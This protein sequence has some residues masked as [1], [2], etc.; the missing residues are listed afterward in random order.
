MSTELSSSDELLGAT[1]YEIVRE[2][3]G[4][5]AGE[6]KECFRV[7]N[8]THREALALLQNWDSRALED[9]LSHIRVVVASDSSDLFP[10]N[11][12]ANPDTTITSYRNSM[13]PLLY[14][15]TKVE[16]DEQGL[17]NLF[18]LR[19]V[20]FLD[21]A[22]DT[23]TFSV[24]GAL[25]DGALKITSADEHPARM[26]FKERV[27]EVLRG[28]KQGGTAVPVR[29][30]ASFALAAAES[31][32]G[33]PGSLE[34]TEMDCLLGRHLVSLDLFGDE[35]WRRDH[36]TSRISRRLS[37]NLLHAELASSQAADLDQDKLVEQC[38]RMNFRSAEGVDL[39]AEER[40]QWRKLCAEYCGN[41]RREI[42]EQIPYFVFEQLFSRDL[43]GLKLGDR[44]RQEIDQR[45]PDRIEEFEQL[46]VKAGLDRRDRDDAQKFL[47]KE[48]EDE[49]E[50]AL[51]DLLSKQTRR[52]VEKA[53]YPNPEKFKN[54]LLKLAQVANAMRA[55]IKSREGGGDY[56]LEM[57]LARNAD[58]A[59]PAIGLLAFLY[60]PTLQAVAEASSL[61][62]DGFEF[63]P[64]SLFCNVQPPPPLLEGRDEESDDE[65]VET[66]EWAAVPVEFA[67]FATDEDGE[68]EL[69]TALEWLPDSLERLAL[70]WL[71][72]CADD[73]P[74]PVAMLGVPQEMTYD[75][76]IDEVVSRVTPLD[77]CERAEIEP[78]IL[79]HPHIAELIAIRTAL[80]EQVQTPG[81]SSDVLS[82]S[83]DDW[84]KL[85]QA[86]KETFIPDGKA[87]PHLSAILGYDCIRGGSDDSMLMLGTHPLRLR[88][89]SKYLRMS[90][91]LALSSL[92]GALS[93][94]S[95]NDSMY[96]NWV[97]HLSPQQQ[98]AIHV[99]PS[100]QRLLAS[101]E[102]GLTEEFFVPSETPGSGQGESIAPPLTAEIVSQ[103]VAYLEAH[104]YKRDR[105]SILLV[106]PVAPRFAADLVRAIRKGEWSDLRI[107]LH[108]AT[109]K[110]L[111]E[112]SSRF[113][114]AVPS[115]NRMT[116]GDDIFPPLELRLHEFGADQD[117]GELFDALEVDLSIVPQFFHGA[118]EIQ[119]NTEPVPDSEGGS[120]DPLLDRPTFI[121]GGT[122]GGAISVSQRPRNP[123]LTLA[124]WSSLVV[125]QHRHKPVAPQ[126]PE[127][128][129]FLEL[130]INFQRA[131]R[132]FADLH[133]RSHWV[134]TL[135]RYITREQ[136][137]ELDSRPEIL[138]VRD[139][140]GPG[141]MFTLIVSS[142]AG[143][144][145]IVRRL[146]R[147]LVSIV[148]RS[149]GNPG[150]ANRQLAERIY[151]ETR[152]IAPRLA[153]KAMGVSRV[154]EEILGLAVGRSLL[155][156]QF[157]VSV[158]KGIVAWISLDEH[159]H[160]FGGS[161]STRADL[162]R[163]VMEEG[164]N[165]L[166]VEI[167]ILEAKL[168]QEGYDP[169]GVEQVQATMSLFRDMMPADSDG[170]DCIDARLWR[171]VLL[172]AIETA[173]TDAVHVAGDLIEDVDTQPHRIPVGMRNVF[174]DGDFKLRALRGVY[175][176]CTYGR[177]A[178]HEV[179]TSADHPGIMIYRS[180]G[181]QLLSLV[182]GEEAPSQM[183][184]GKKAGDLERDEEA[185]SAQA[186]QQAG[187]EQEAVEKQEAAEE[188]EEEVV[189]A[190]RGKLPREELEG[191]YQLI[192]DTYA[193]FGTAVRKPENYE[194]QFV[195]GPAS[196]L[197]R[198]R[199]GHGVDP[200]KIS[201]KADV[202]RLNL[203]LEEEQRVRFSIDRG[204][205]TIDVPKSAVDR[206][207]VMA[208]DL[209]GR[210]Q[211]QEDML[212]VPIGEDRFGE[213][214]VLNFSSSNSPHLLIGGTTG[215]GKSEALNTILAGLTEHYGP[216]ELRLM[217]VD[218]KGTELQHLAASEHLEG[219]IGWDEQDANSLLERAVIE[220][221]RR[222]QLFKEARTRTLPEYNEIQEDGHRIPWWLIVLDEY[223]DLTSDADAKKLIESHLRRLAQKARAAGIHVV[224]AT[225]K[226]SAEV[227]S[228]NLRSNLPAQIALKVK[229][230]TESRVVMDETGAETLN[231]KGDAFFKSEGKLLRVQC[232]KV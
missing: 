27:L 46:A 73:R 221:Q 99:S 143:R 228:T 67:L 75:A 173:N 56:R 6:D 77:S 97:S 158:G 110:N 125:R 43:K 204:S 185:G 198:I 231:G 207:F 13:E 183:A 196:V 35:Y 2:G 162:C 113:F 171:E 219:D 70:L 103:V 126:Q 10:A 89:L 122:R 118:P 174:R 223:A 211:R 212:S 200:K 180:S 163:I 57:R 137:E 199:P 213:P 29:K 84:N 31:L 166:E 194:D 1:T 140:V 164:E 168:R 154:T 178:G 24:P 197:Y 217:L 76:W 133:E 91:T 22:F 63:A 169:H 144:K 160:W 95:Q 18:T 131:S 19:D 224:I 38:E 40:D 175:S 42:R 210:W 34:A 114:E 69:E 202:L 192:L 111:W 26:L 72:L 147:K 232:A 82:S 80:E 138:T 39:P 25:A 119:E 53:A 187:Y 16:S 141:G 145:F 150:V 74:G 88:W 49:E 120:F 100:G 109:P 105:L 50:S 142:N 20:N 54:P 4:R 206:Y 184:D 132:L 55:S 176:I 48:P 191:R 188:R 61:S 47:D 98:P 59:N 23:E 177:S 155:E 41:P 134:I 157:P 58:T 135:E 86:A 62:A 151:D 186:E 127:N 159:S 71:T 190:A 148:E 152:E 9:R 92:E 146:E 104:P 51:R 220:M 52:M 226:P 115:D 83:F 215:S 37:Q 227:I 128:I 182:V 209:W 203:R 153:L 195:E 79:T 181:S 102:A 66:L 12:R 85:L 156:Q 14:I 15:E 32:A 165:G 30:F 45:P 11:Y 225:Q 123:D 28:L 3:F 130:R 44:V 94:N 218:P 33:K 189:A 106:S 179:R 170:E 68:I 230:A 87:D 201:E 139:R 208:A 129:D 5:G 161:S 96:L 205:I 93:L 193:E 17:K 65:S 116:S 108:L 149:G 124:S 107:T 117:A 78:E 101:T 229:S 121:Y 167:L 222:Y 60:G 112:A 172:S 36:S 64:D 81:L 136:I 90:E 216:D 8:L 21:G 7:K 214:V